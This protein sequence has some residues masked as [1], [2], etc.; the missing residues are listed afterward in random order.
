MIESKAG[1][2][3]ANHYH[4]TDWHYCYVISGQIR[5]FYRDLKSNKKPELLIVEKGKYGIHPS[6]GRTL[7]EI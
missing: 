6:T 5:Y 2:L 1:S 3:R 7:Y 4:K